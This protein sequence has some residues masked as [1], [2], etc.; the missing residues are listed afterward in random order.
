MDVN[1]ANNITKIVNRMNKCESFLGRLENRS[2]P[3]EFVIYY[4]GGET[5][6]LEEDALSLLIKY[7]RDQIKEAKEQLNKL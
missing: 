6:R 7:Y 3:D 1:K 5:C 2:Y 4:R